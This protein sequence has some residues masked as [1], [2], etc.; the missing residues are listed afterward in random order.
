MIIFLY[1]KTEKRKNTFY[2][3]Y[4]TIFQFTR[5]ISNYRYI[6]IQ[7]VIKK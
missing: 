2:N 1:N 4:E 3:V 6:A 7:I 5:M